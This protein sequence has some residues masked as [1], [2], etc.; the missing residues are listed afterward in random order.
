MHVELEQSPMYD[1]ISFTKLADEQLMSRL[2]LYGGSNASLHEDFENIS[3][4][5]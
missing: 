3:D 4:R 5:S 2:F 1:L